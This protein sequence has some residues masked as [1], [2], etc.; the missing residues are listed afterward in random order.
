MNYISNNTLITQN[1]SFT[2]KSGLFRR[3]FRRS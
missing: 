1:T 3:T 2:G